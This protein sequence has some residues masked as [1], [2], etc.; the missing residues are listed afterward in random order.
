MDR[1][2]LHDKT[3]ELAVPHSRIAGAIARVADRINA[4]YAGRTPLLLGVL[5]GS[6]MFMSELVQRLRIPCEV[7]F[8]KL[9]SYDGTRSTGTVNELIGLTHSIAGRDVIVVEDIV[10]TGESIAHMFSLL[11]PQRPASIEVAT[12]LLKPELYRKEHPIR[13]AA[14]EVPNDFLVGF[15]LDYNQLGRNLGDLYKITDDNIR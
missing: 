13:Y 7:S 2:T 11:G 10:E 1:V 15:G 14:L 5:N 4:D 12:L 3:F 8:I 9:A 6:F